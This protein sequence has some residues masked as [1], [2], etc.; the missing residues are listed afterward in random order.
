MTFPLYTTLNSGLPDKDLTI[1]QKNFLMKKIPELDDNTHELIFVLLKCA[2]N[3][4]S[5]I[6]YNGIEDGKKMVFD[7][8]NL[9][10]RTRQLIH[11]FVLLHTQRLAE[12]DE[13]LQSVPE[14]Y[15]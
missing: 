8:T 2:S 15:Q 1:A 13:K 6:P 9:P 14:Q 12:E 11:K 7:L 5:Q 3:D 10:K 4:P